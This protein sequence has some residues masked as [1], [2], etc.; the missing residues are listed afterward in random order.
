MRSWFVSGRSVGGERHR[1]LVD[2]NKL[3]WTRRSHGD[4]GSRVFRDTGS[5]ESMV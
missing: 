1:I 5:S 4:D 2:L 3:M